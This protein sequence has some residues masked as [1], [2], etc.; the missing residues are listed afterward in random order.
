MGEPGFWD[1]QAKAAGI[2]S[3][4]ARLSRRLERYERLQGE[5]DDARELLDMDGGDMAEEIARALEPVRAELERLQEEA[6]F[7]GEYDAGDAVVSIHAGEG[8]T[9]A[10]DWAEMLLRMYLRWA[11]DR[12]FTTELVEASAGRGGR[13]Q[14]GHVHGQGRE[15]LRDAQG[16]ARRAPAR[17]PVAVRQRAPAAHVVRAGDRRSADRRRRRRSRSTRATCASTPTA[18]AAR[19]A[20]T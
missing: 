12:G 9:D 10:Q 1:D 14:V 3:E 7:T 5:Y 17:P 15:R 8:G 4:H 6:L 18:R 11:E 13:P 2:S 16:R 19:A 20:S